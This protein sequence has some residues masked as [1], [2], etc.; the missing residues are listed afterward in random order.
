M[1]FIIIHVKKLVE[2]NNKKYYYKICIFL[3]LP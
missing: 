2:Q 1:T 3:T